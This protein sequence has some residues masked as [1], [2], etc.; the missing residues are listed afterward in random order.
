MWVDL[1]QVNE[2]V[3]SVVKGI[4]AIVLEPQFEIKKLRNRFM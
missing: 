2:A 1:L 4:T 3:A